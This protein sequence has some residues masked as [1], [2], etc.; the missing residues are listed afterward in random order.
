MG[1]DRAYKTRLGKT[2]VEAK[3]GIHCGRAAVEETA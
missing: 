1:G 3:A 2:G